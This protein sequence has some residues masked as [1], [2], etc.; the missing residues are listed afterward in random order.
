[1]AEE[2]KEEQQKSENSNSADST[3]KKND[4]NSSN[5]YVKSED[6]NKIL[7]ELKEL[8]SQPVTPPKTE[9]TTFFKKWFSGMRGVVT[10]LVLVISMLFGACGFAGYL[11]NVRTA[12]YK[13]GYQAGLD[14]GHAD[15]VRMYSD[16]AWYSRLWSVFTAKFPGLGEDGKIKK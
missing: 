9:E 10:S 11:D 14:V 12:G 4:E 15:M 13:A 3:Q 7:D 6:L 1:M 16:S 5:S 8:R 2:K